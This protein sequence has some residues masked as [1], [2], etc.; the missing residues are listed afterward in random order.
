MVS[1][2]Q[3][4][5]ATPSSFSSAAEAYG[6]L[7]ESLSNRVDPIDN[8]AGDLADAWTGEDQEGGTAAVEYVRAQNTSITTSAGELSTIQSALN[9]LAEAVTRAQGDI[10][11]AKEAAAAIPAT[12]DSQGKVTVDWSSIDTEGMEPSDLS[13][14]R[15]AKN[16]EAEKVQKDIDD[17][18]EKATEADE[19][20]RD[21]IGDI[22]PT[23]APAGGSPPAQMPEDDWTP[24]QVNDWWNGLTGAERQYLLANEPEA[25]GERDGIPTVYRDLANRSI[26]NERIE[27]LEGLTTRGELAR[28]G[29][30]EAANRQDKLEELLAIREHLESGDSGQRRYLLGFD[31]SQNRL[32]IANGNPDTADNVFTFVPGALNGFGEYDDSMSRVDQMV[33]DANGVNGSGN[34]AGIMWLDYDS[35]TVG[36]FGEFNAGMAAPDLQEFQAGMRATHEG[37]PSTNTVIGHSYGTTVVG[38]AAMGDIDSDQVLFLGSVGTGATDVS[39]FTVDADDVYAGVTTNDYEAH[40]PLHTKPLPHWESFGA[41]AFEAGEG[42]HSDYWDENTTSR[43]QIAD[44]VTGN[45]DRIDPMEYVDLNAPDPEGNDHY[46]SY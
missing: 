21:S 46:I 38:H 36:T 12:V 40:I 33:S 27:T 29:V 19:D 3:L 31:T 23:A 10:D 22:S 34:T 42:R 28:I 18:V 32:I 37:P 11:D 8:Q 39:D 4:V 41:T 44:I 13:L 35:P 15:A 14:L 6:S 30:I 17:A 20:A 43:D 5:D 1:Y 24:E 25:I 9:D 2:K 26:L 45:G 7:S 16:G